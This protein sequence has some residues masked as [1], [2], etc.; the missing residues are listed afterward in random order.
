MDSVLLG[1]AIFF[2]LFSVYFFVFHLMY[3]RPNKII[4][5]KHCP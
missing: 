2:M 3:V 4:D 1:A 5:L